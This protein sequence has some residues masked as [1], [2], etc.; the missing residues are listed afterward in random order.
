MS[1]LL[2][3]RFPVSLTQAENLPSLPA[4]AVEV[5]QQT[6]D[7]DCTIDILAETISRDPALAAKL[8]RLSNSSLFKI[9]QDVT[10][11][12]RAAMVLGLKTVKLMSL[13]FSLVDALPTSGTEAG[14]DFNAFWHRSLVTAVAARRLAGSGSGWLCGVGSGGVSFERPRTRARN[15]GSQGR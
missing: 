6:Q 11:L 15:G 2:S 1:S 4:V 9:G 13:S 10:T 7:D 5:I 8:L 3:D 12:S 14:F